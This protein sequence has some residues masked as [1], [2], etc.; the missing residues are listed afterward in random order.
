M[1]CIMLFLVSACSAGGSTPIVS[2]PDIPPAETYVLTDPSVPV[3]VAAGSEFYI[4]VPSNPST[5]YYWQAMNSWDPNVFVTVATEYQST[6]PEGVVGGGGMDIWRFDAIG[7]GEETL[8]LSYFPP[9][10]TGSPEQTLTFTIRV[11]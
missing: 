11:K 4:A 2:P 1:L 10:I 3:E 7:A 6:S 5:G 8:V 9:G